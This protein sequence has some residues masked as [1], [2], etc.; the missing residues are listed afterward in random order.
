MAALALDVELGAPS[1]DNYV[2]EGWGEPEGGHR[3]AIGQTSRLRLPIADRGQTHVLVL[4]VV[5]WV[6]PP[7]ISRQRIVIGFNG[8][9]AE[10]LAITHRMAIGFRVPAA[11]TLDGALVVS[12]DSL[13]APTNATI[14]RYRDG[15]AM[16]VMVLSVRLFRETSRPPA[17]SVVLPPVPVAEPHRQELLQGFESL[18]HRCAFG[19]LQRRWNVDI[20]G[21]LRFAGIH[22]PVLIR[23]L[24][25]QFSGLG[26]EAE[27]HAF[28]REDSRGLYSV[29]DRAREMWFN[30]SQPTD[31]FTPSEVTALAARRL[32]FLRRKFLEDV[33]SGERIFVVNSPYPLIEAE[34]LAL[35]TALDLATRNTLLW[36]NQTGNLPPG[37]VR[38]TAAGLYYGQLDKAGQVKDDPSDDA[39]FSICANTRQLVAE[40]QAALSLAKRST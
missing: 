32:A 11:Q 36:T 39:W 25:R 35:F 26:S 5:P 12:I 34:A 14:D 23:E 40:E 24:I 19:L 18:G 38:R 29:Y 9:F 1:G 31:R 8:R 22:T 20:L 4:D 28:I 30:T 27:L 15:S 13:D 3:W 37:T 7:E 6:H 21:L 33:A 17:P 16:N 10:T 2:I